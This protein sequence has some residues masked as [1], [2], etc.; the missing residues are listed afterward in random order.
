MRFREPAAVE[1]RCV[2]EAEW[3]REGKPKGM[4]KRGGKACEK[5]GSYVK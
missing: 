4:K 1:V 3:V 5:R 2:Y